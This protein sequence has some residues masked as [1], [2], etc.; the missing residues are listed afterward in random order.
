VQAKQQR[1]EEEGRK[2]QEQQRRE[3]VQIGAT[4]G[5]MDPRGWPITQDMQVHERTP[6]ISRQGSPREREREQIPRGGGRT[7]GSARSRLPAERT[8]VGATPL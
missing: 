6:R 3:E 1:K 7:G 2:R 8:V 4:L 5:P